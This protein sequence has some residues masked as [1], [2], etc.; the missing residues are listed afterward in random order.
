M[1][2]LY[3]KNQDKYFLVFFI[4]FYFV[5]M[6]ILSACMSNITH[7]CSACRGLT[8]VLNSLGLEFQMFVSCCVD[9]GNQ[10]LERATNGFN[11]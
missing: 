2:F 3:K 9:A 10:T 11:H 7:E 1:W 6:G 8:G 4:Y 5:Y